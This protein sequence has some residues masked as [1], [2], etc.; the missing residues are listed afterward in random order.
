VTARVLVAGEALVDEV[1]AADGRQVE[2]AP[3]GGPLNIAVTLARLGVPTDLLTSFGTDAYGDGIAAHLDGSGVHLFP[4]SRGRAP[5]S[6]AQARLDH[7]NQATYDFDLHWDPPAAEPPPECQAVHVGS[8]GTVVEPGA[9]RMHA[10][11]RR[12]HAADVVVSYDPN[13]RPTVLG[14]VGDPWPDVRDLAGAAALVKLSDED[15]AY[16]RPGVSE[17]RVLD[18]LLRG[19]HTLLAVLTRG[20]QGLRL[21][22]RE[23]R[24]DVPAV[25]VDVVDTVGAGDACMGGLLAALFLGARL[26]LASLQRLESADLEQVGAVAARVAALTCSRRGADPPVRDELP[27][28]AFAPRR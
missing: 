9:T 23:H 22:T 7:R 26:D 20:Q 6:V 3:G 8:L 25:P 5:T 12:A 1:L 16:L 11:V 19:A 18:D 24:V 4:G 21:A 27:A 28:D 2:A 14:E 15:A 10:L 13:V 17:D